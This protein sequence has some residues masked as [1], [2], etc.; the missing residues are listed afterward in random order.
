M[1][2]EEVPQPPPKEGKEVR[3]HATAHPV[4]AEH[5]MSVRQ[6]WPLPLQ[7]V[8]RATQEMARDVN[9]TQGGTTIR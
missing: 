9:A 6:I 8:R 5:S 2:K 1:P 3:E 7:S 4:V